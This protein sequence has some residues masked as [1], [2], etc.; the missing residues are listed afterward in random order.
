VAARG[1]ALENEAL[2]ERVR[3]LEAKLRQSP[4]P[5]LKRAPAPKRSRRT[6]V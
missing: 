2:R 3:L 4:V 5:P 6:R 1:T